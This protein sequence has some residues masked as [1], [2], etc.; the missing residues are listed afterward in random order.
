MQL[1]NKF[2][3]NRQDQQNMQKSQTLLT[4]RLIKKK[5]RASDSDHEL[6]DIISISLSSMQHLERLMDIV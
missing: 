3:L 5:T 2:I 4:N 1:I 6:V